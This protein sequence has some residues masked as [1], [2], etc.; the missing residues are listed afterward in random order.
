[1]RADTYDLEAVQRGIKL[2]E[3][4][5]GTIY[6]RKYTDK[7]GNNWSTGHGGDYPW[8]NGVNG[9][10]RLSYS[11]DGQKYEVSVYAYGDGVRV[12]CKEFATLDAAL[13]AGTRET[14]RRLTET[15]AD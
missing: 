7:V 9:T 12:Y 10:A 5:A 8:H 3:R 11:E 6:R 1:M 13:R 4:A 2:M 14:A 15:E